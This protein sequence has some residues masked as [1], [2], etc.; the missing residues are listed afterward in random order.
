MIW[1]YRSV[2][3]FLSTPLGRALAGAGAII[4]AVLAILAY[5]EAKGKQEAKERELRRE[6]RVTKK[7]E[8]LEDEVEGLS[9]DDLVFRSGRW[10][11]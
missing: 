8:R 6:L 2:G 5:G 11:R 1:I 9:N 10:V 7:R 4:G 3:K